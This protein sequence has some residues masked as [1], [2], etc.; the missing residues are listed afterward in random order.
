MV[1][2]TEPITHLESGSESEDVQNYW[3]LN[4]WTNSIKISEYMRQ[5]NTVGKVNGKKIMIRIFTKSAET[6]RERKK[7]KRAGTYRAC[8]KL[9]RAIQVY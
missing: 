3:R 5:K 6:L 1:P 8:A 7:S 9:T 4:L 2:E